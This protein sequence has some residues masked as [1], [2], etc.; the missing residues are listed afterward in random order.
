MALLERNQPFTGAHQGQL[1]FDIFFNVKP[2]NM[3]NP[4]QN[5]HGVVII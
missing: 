5:R 4:S 1:Y 2:N 3:Y